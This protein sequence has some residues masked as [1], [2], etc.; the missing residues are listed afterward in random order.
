MSVITKGV[1][2]PRMLG[3]LGVA[4]TLGLLHLFSES[5]DSTTQATAASRLA[6]GIVLPTLRTDTA[7]TSRPME[8]NSAIRASEARPV[9][10]PAS[11]NPFAWSAPPL[12]VSKVAVV[13]PVAPVV[14]SPLPP[15]APVAPP[16]NLSFAGRVSDPDG[17]Q[18]LYL[19]WGDKTLTAEVGVVLPNGYRVERITVDAV[20]FNYVELNAPARFAIPAAPRYEIR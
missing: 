6:Q 12:P 2:Q 15:P 14:V 8:P 10:E 7:T 20:E 19:T 1:L 17:K 18:T 5:V 11:R 9:L 3:L 16:L 13:Q 4:A